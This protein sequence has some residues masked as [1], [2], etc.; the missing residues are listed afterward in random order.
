MVEWCS[1]EV[2]EGM[3]LRDE[4]GMRIPD[5]S[6]EQYLSV[7]GLQLVLL[8]SIIFIIGLVIN[9]NIV[10]IIGAIAPTLSML[11]GF[12]FTGPLFFIMPLV[13]IGYAIYF[14]I[15][16]IT[17]GHKQALAYFY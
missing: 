1:E 10:M 4:Y 16:W 2:R 17:K 5:I 3:I 8:G 15:L 11:V 14:W 12:G 13:F 7:I 9:N 6:I